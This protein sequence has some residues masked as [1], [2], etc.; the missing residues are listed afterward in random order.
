MLRH[1]L[2][3][4]FTMNAASFTVNIRVENQIFSEP[5]EP[6][7]TLITAI[8]TSEAEPAVLEW[9][10]GHSRHS[11]NQ[12]GFQRCFGLARLGTGRKRT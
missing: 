6:I 5:T 9:E 12:L 8:T 11:S 4:R 10:D 3:D 1:T 2:L 7:S